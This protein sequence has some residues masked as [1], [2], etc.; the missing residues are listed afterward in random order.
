VDFVEG[1]ETVAVTAIFNER[2]LQ[3]RLYPRNF[4]EVDVTL[5][6]LF[7]RCLEVEFVETVAAEHDDPS[8]LRVRRVDKHALCHTG[9]TPRS[10]V[11]PAR[12]SGGDVILAG[13]KPAAPPVNPSNGMILGAMA[14]LVEAAAPRRHAEDASGFIQTASSERYRQE[15]AAPQ[16]HRP[17][18]PTA[19]P[20]LRPHGPDRQ[21]AVF[22]T[23]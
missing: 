7:G 21:T 18:N 9:I 8:F 3:R 12:I 22:R 14:E 5:Y 17:G 16:G 23:D 19:A 4:R 11:P 15:A 1:E 10:V 2:G 20:P 13:A 6:L